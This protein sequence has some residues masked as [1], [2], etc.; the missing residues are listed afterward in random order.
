MP[1]AAPPSR[2]NWRLAVAILTGLLLFVS[3]AMA[4]RRGVNVRVMVPGRSDSSAV[5]NAMRAQYDGLLSH[6]VRI[7]EWQGPMMHAKAVVVDRVWCSVGTYNLDHRSLRHNLE[8]NAN[9]LD[10]ALAEELAAQFELGLQGS[11]E[12]TLADWR[13]RP[14][15]ARVQ[16][17]FWSS[18]DYF[19]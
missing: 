19:F 5:W 7:F 18:F 9:V 10:R 4:A 17:R 12:I 11:R 2:L 16:E 8:V 6:G 1:K 3:T 14:W 13:R 15:T